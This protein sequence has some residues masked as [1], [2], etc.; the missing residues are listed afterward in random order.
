MRSRAATDSLC[1]TQ[2][3][4]GFYFS[5]VL[6]VKPLIITLSSCPLSNTLSTRISVKPL[7]FETYVIMPAS[8][9]IEKYIFGHGVLNPSEEKTCRIKCF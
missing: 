8:M 1:I 3:T 7:H 9:Y 5:E 4:S 2:R 6:A